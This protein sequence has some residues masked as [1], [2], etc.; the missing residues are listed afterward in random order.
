[1]PD[2]RFF[3]YDAVQSTYAHMEAGKP[4]SRSRAFA[5]V[6]SSL[7]PL[8]TRPLKCCRCGIDGIDLTYAMFGAIRREGGTEENGITVGE[9]FAGPTDVLHETLEGPQGVGLAPNGDD[10]RVPGVT[11]DEDDGVPAA[12]DVGGRTEGCGRVLDDVGRDLS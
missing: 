4:E 9:K 5:T 8:S 7:L 10:V 6:L 3:K 12:V 2:V 11:V 1:M